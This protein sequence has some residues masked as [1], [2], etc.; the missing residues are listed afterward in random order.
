MDGGRL[1]VD[2]LIDENCRIVDGV[3]PGRSG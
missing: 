1:G 2:R 3:Q